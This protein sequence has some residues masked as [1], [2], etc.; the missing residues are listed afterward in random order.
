[1]GMPKHLA[2]L[3]KNPQKKGP[4]HGKNLFGTTELIRQNV[5]PP[6]NIPGHQDDRMSL[7]PE[8]CLGSHATQ[9]MRDA[10]HPPVLLELPTAIQ[11]DLDGQVVHH[12]EPVIFEGATVKDACRSNLVEE[13]HSSEAMWPNNCC[14]MRA[15]GNESRKKEVAT[16]QKQTRRACDRNTFTK[17]MSISIPKILDTSGWLEVYFSQLTMI[18]RSLHNWSPKAATGSLTLQ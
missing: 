7:G 3:L 2:N 18:P 14:H 10:E 13:E 5:L 15:G 11:R 9:S 8:D 12:R 17:D 6:R 16:S 1:M 4:F